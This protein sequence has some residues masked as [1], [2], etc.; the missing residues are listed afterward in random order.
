MLAIR[1]LVEAYA[2]AVLRR[3]ADDWAACWADDA[4]WEL[5][6]M[7]VESRAAI[8]ALWEQAMSG[9]TF[10]GFFVQPGPLAIDGDHAQGRVWTHEL[11]VHA[12]GARRQT[13]GRYDDS[14]VRTPE[15]WRF[16]TRRFAVQQEF[17]L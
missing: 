12:D 3:D 6:D 15:G 17:A 4:V 2:D 11:L 1:Q 13:V 10:V 9:F 16:A 7:R 14:Y 8:R 5:L